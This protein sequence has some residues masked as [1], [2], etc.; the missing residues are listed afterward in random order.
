M[1]VY[2]SMD[3][4]T[5]LHMRSGCTCGKRYLDYPNTCKARWPSGP[6]RVTQAKGCKQPIVC[7]KFRVSHQGNPGVGSN[8][9]L[10]TF[11]LRNP[12]LFCCESSFWSNLSIPTLADRAPIRSFGT[13]RCAACFTLVPQLAS[14]YYY[15]G[16]I[17]NVDHLGR[18]ADLR[19]WGSI[20][21]AGQR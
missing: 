7:L 19:D 5:P 18:A 15:Q 11:F 9:T 4:L 20:I 3:S 6:R 21:H 13:T 2:P 14:V 1:A 12:S 16:E 8:P 10:V 17:T